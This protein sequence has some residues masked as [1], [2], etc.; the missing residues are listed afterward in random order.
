MLTTKE[1][2]GTQNLRVV[3]VAVG[4]SLAVVFHKIVGNFLLVPL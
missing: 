3:R 1:I 4:G 2:I